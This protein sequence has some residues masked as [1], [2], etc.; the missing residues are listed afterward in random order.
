M[1]STKEELLNELL[2][3][4]NKATTPE[5]IKYFF[6][7]YLKQEKIYKPIY[8]LFAD[9]F[10]SIHSY[11]ALMFDRCWSQAGA[12][13]RTAIEQISTLAVLV[14]DEQAMKDYLAL[15]ILKRQYYQT[16]SEEECKKFVKEHNLPKDDYSRKA[17]FDYSWIKSITKKSKFSY[18][19]IVKEAR[20]DEVLGDIDVVLNKFVHGKLTIF[21]FAGPNDSWE[22]MKKYGRRA[23]MICAKLFDFLCCSYKKFTNESE[24][25]KV[26]NNLFIPFKNLY[27]ECLEKK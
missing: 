4:I 19:D 2:C 17:Y 8:N 14:N 10:L 5:N 15:D 13:L 9:S 11:T 12:I 1:P 7:Y 24:V 26:T 23:N 18:K 22:V 6:E 16:E 20:L 21:D 27:L 25:T 3:F